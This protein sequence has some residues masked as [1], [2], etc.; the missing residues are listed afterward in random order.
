M[1]EFNVIDGIVREVKMDGD[2]FFLLKI[3]ILVLQNRLREI[4]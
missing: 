1:H 2:G 4:L 3:C